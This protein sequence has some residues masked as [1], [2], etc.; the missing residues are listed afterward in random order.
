MVPDSHAILLKPV[1]IGPVT[2]KNRF[3]AV[4]HATGHGYLQP[5]AASALREMKARGGWGVVAVQ[6]NEIDPTSDAASHPMDRFWAGDT[7]VHAAQAGRIKSHGALA[8]IELGH[9]GMRARN[10]ATGEPVWG[11]SALPILRPEIPVEAKAMDRA[12]IKAFRASHAAAVR[13]AIEAGYDIVYVYA[14]HDLSIL[15]H[16]LS[17]RTNQRADEYGGSLGNRLR[18]LRETLVDAQD[19]SN[20]KVAIALRYSVAD[21]DPSDPGRYAFDG[22]EGRAV[23]EMLAEIPD[24]WDVNISSWSADSA[25]SRF[26]GEG[27]QEPFTAFVKRATSKPVVG[28][29]R[30]TSPDHMAAL[31]RK[32]AVDLIGAARPSIADPFLPAKIAEGRSDDIRECIGCNVCVGM[33]GYGVPIRCT[34]NPTISE[35]GARRWHPEFV[36]AA[37]RSQHVLVVGGGPAGLECALTLARGGV[38]VTLAEAGKGFGGRVSAEAGLAGLAAWRRV[39]DYR[40]HHLQAHAD[41]SLYTDSEMTAETIAQMSADH[42]MLATGARWRAD[43][44]GR[45]RFTPMPGFSE[46]G[47]LTPDDVMAGRTGHGDVLIYDDEH[48]YMGGV[49]AEHLARQGRRVAIA[50]PLLS[51][52][53]WTVNTL[54]QRHIVGR[55]L[56]LGVTML[57]AATLTSTT[58]DTAHFQSAV[59]GE[60]LPSINYSMLVMVGARLPRLALHAS[61]LASGFAADHVSLIG[62]CL[63]PGL[64]QRAV[65]SGHR[66]ARQLIES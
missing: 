35:E 15:S 21:M 11:P 42:V 45:S 36:P 32:G 27:H 56:K 22:E 18:L 28:V 38:K 62:D 57:T 49:L 65:Y 60:T 54:E 3:Y 2:A 24:L 51:I 48:N 59:T 41:V 39:R 52:S 10:F 9:M 12:D 58:T 8:A 5:D 46:Q 33:D 19:A 40:L 30:Y 14:A 55:L 7:G 16:F 29:G 47:A 20:G 63:A 64:I 1:K 44:V 34:Q 6:F 31:I 61:L 43:G 17:R 53:A 37:K 26:A 4:P 66:A 50:T 23:V 13:R 25:S